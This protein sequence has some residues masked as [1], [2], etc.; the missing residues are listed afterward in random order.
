MYNLAMGDIDV[1]RACDS[2][3][4]SLMTTATTFSWDKDDWAS[5]N[6]MA[7]GFDEYRPAYSAGLAGHTLDVDGVY[8]DS[9]EK[10]VITHGFGE[11]TLSWSFADSAETTTGEGEGYELFEMQP[12][13][14]YLHYR[15]NSAGHPTVVSAAIDTVAGLVTGAVGELGLEPHTHLARQRWFRGIIRGGAAETEGRGRLHERTDELVGR[16]VRYAYSSDDVYDHVYLNTN[17]FTWLCLG[18]AEIG[19]GDTDACTYWKLRENTYLFSW[20][21]KNVGVEGMVLVDLN[22]LRSVGIQ[23]G[24]DQQSGDLVNI[25]MGSYAHEFE[26][27]GGVDEVRP[28]PPSA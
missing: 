2:S 18:G 10:V 7:D 6:E 25:T 5:L 22:A 13:L 21:E 28:T 20:L 3:K 14:F 11:E 19:V 26:R 27:A 24:L 12:G 4:D 16:R 23:F 17:L 15:R 8:D 1:P 9:G